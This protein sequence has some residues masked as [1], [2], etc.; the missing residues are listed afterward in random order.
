MY[1]SN[2]ISYVLWNDIQLYSPREL[3]S[4]FIEIVVPNKPNSILGTI[5]Q[6]PSMKPYKFNSE[7]LEPLLSKIKAEG[8]VTF[9]AGDFNVNLI[10]Y[11][12][13]KGTAEFLEHIFFKQFY[14][15][16]HSPHK[17]NFNITNT[18]W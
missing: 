11:N 16:Y 5:Y 9:L 17:I 7:F 6:H 14:S 8:K 18:N 15:A 1:I 12:Q 4:I 3:E 13:N 10:K 2:D